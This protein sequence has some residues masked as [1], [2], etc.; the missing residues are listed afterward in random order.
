M[1]SRRDIFYRQLGSMLDA[2]I[3]VSS[4]FESLSGQIGSSA[5]GKALR[6][7][8]ARLSGGESISS[9]MEQERKFFSPF[10]IGIIRAGEESGELAR[11]TKDLAGIM[12]EN[13]RITNAVIGG[14]IY[15]V[16]LFHMAVLLPP[17]FLLITRGLGA[18][19]GTVLPVLLIVYLVVGVSVFIYNSSSSNDRAVSAIQKTLMAVPI[20]GKLMVQ[21]AIVSFVRVMGYLLNAG[22][23]NAE[24]YETAANACGNLIIRK[25][26]MDQLPFIRGGGKLS[27]ALSQYRFINP[28]II[29]MIHTGEESGDLGD[30]LLRAADMLEEDYR[31]GIKA[32]IVLLTGLI[33]FIVA[34]YI[35]YI[36]ISFYVGYFNRI[37]QLI[38]HN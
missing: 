23:T 25:K 3:P 8:S 20:L 26:L 6:R 34:V 14:L 13:R 11:L 33:F 30:M 29:Q 27:D 28:V 2:G 22:L 35:G 12:E 7:I 4:A 10:E 32:G 1:F 31:N 37:F 17:L 38:P 9:C 24:A 18:Y 16:L 15:P 19:L 21:G 5:F 36:I